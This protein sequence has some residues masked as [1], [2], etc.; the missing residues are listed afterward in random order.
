MAAAS[1]TTGVDATLGNNRDSDNNAAD[2]VVRPA[3]QPQ[4]KA[5]A[6]EP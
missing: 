2:F 5:S 1:M 6:P 3:R 4:N